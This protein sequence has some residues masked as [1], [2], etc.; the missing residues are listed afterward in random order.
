[1]VPSDIKLK[2]V[3]MKT[4]YLAWLLPLLF[5][6]CHKDKDKSNNSNGNSFTYTTT[7]DT[8][9]SSY[10]NRS[11]DFSYSVNVLTGSIT[12]NPITYSI[13]GLPANVTVAPG[14]QTVTT[15]LGGVFNFT[16]GAIAPGNYTLNFTSKTAGVTALTHPLTLKILAFPDYGDKLA[17]TYGY[18]YDY[19]TPAD[20]IYNYT[21]VVTKATDTP[22]KITI[23]N[24]R[25]LGAS[26]VVT[27][28]L[29]NVV[30]IPVQ[31]VNGY[32][33]WG[34]GVYSHDNTPFDTSYMLVIN[35]TMVH[36][37]DTEACT[38]HI[39]RSH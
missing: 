37:L 33:I 30:R 16:I 7:Y 4:H 28:V 8:I 26:F 32:T 5:C 27:A 22:Y 19:C 21:S 3:L 1:M 15:L 29:S 12:T 23:S 35:D 2:F 13:S 9:I 38:M 20:M 39:Q 24:V 14:S 34:T 31:T 18:A 10:A 25:N 36:A 17:G 11:L 6:C